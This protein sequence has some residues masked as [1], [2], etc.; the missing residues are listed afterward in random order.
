MTW[1][2]T[3]KSTFFP[4]KN[5]LFIICST[6]IPKRTHR[7]TIE[8][9]KLREKTLFSVRLLLHSISM[10]EFC[11]RHISRQTHTHKINKKITLNI[12]SDNN[13]NKKIYI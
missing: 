7:H 11:R 4:Y 3:H 2:Q 13:N 1:N 12:C 10:F 9:Q 6:V 8:E 5:A